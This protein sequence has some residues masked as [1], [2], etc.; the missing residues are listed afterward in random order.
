MSKHNLRFDHERLEVYQLALR[1]LALANLVA[2]RLP[3]GR[4]YLADQLRRAATSIVLNI[5]EG[6]EEF[7]RDEKKRFYRIA[8]RS[9]AECAAVLDVARVITNNQIEE[10]VEARGL[11]IRIV[12]MLVRLS[13]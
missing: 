9:G 1:F 11:L 13:K 3:R 8:K 7:A 6:A 5:A 10:R 12:S 4:S 2:S